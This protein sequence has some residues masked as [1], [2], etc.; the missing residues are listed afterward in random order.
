MN[1]STPGF[2]TAEELA[3]VLNRARTRSLAVFPVVAHD[4][5]L[6]AIEWYEGGNL[7]TAVVDWNPDSRRWI[8]ADE[9]DRILSPDPQVVDPEWLAQL[10]MVTAVE[11][12]MDPAAVC[13]GDLSAPLC[14]CKRGLTCGACGT[15]HHWECPDREDADYDAR[16]DEDEE[17]E[18]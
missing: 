6:Y 14:C 13:S 18:D 10:H 5:W 9:N 8:V 15:G 7:R 2:S 1:A 17:D 11:V 12:E 3:F 4:G 16:D